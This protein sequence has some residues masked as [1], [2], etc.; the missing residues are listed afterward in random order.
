MTTVFQAMKRISVIDES[1]MAVSPG[2]CCLYIHI[3]L[4]FI[5]FSLMDRNR[6]KFIALCE[7]RLPDENTD[8]E[9]NTLFQQDEILAAKGYYKIVISFVSQKSVLVPAVFYNAD[10]A[11][12]YLSLTSSLTDSETLC[13][14]Q[15][16]YTDVVHIYSLPSDLV[17]RMQSVYPDCRI[18]HS[19]TVLMESELLRNKNST[20]PCIA[21]N[22]RQGSYDI[23]VTTGNQLNYFNTFTYQGSEDFIYY[24]L[25]TME[26][27]H[28]NPE[29][30]LLRFSG[31]VEK[32]TATYIITAKYVRNISFGNRPEA[33]E[34]SYGFGHIQQH[35]HAIVL[36]QYLC[37]S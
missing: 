12:G 35:A 6:N 26:Q 31:E 25:Y 1:L 5:S 37:E 30:T 28:L 10:D 34:F 9:F 2:D 4:P 3:A 18:I 33:F 14:D 32:H 16:K 24:L 22:I 19:G 36:N 21:V 8:E 23:A 11:K 20:D 29:K 7:Y 27:L 15:L 17:N 13:A